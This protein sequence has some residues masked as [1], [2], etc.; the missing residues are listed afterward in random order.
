MQYTER[1]KLALTY[2]EESSKRAR[3]I[4]FILQL[5]VIVVLASLWQQA[6][7]NWLQQRL[8]AA[9]DLVRVL[10]CQPDKVYGEAVVNEAKKSVDRGPSLMLTADA[11]YLDS[12]YSCAAVMKDDAKVK[13]AYKYQK[14]WGFSLAEAK[15]NVSDLQQLMVNRVLGVSFPVLG[16][17][18]DVNDLSLLAGVTFVIL[19]SWFH[20]ALRRQN[21]NIIHV[22][23]IARQA[24][25]SGKEPDNCLSVTYYLLAMTQVLTIPPADE[26]DTQKPT[27]FAKMGKLSNLIMSTAV[28]AQALVL[29]DD[30]LTMARGDT[31]SPIVNYI[32]SGLAALLWFYLIFRTKECYKIMANTQ[33]VW[34]EAFNDAR[35]SP[36]DRRKASEKGQLPPVSS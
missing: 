28:V 18:F 8:Y 34:N 12:K 29:I 19:L 16:V 25:L 7:S 31:L 32:E 3:W 33:T 4:V 13:R 1:I 5:A 24:D 9:Q 36:A 14:D 27:F 6:D 15:K 10:S 35:I 11:E 21:K 30:G 26:K 22:F 20:F 2:A 23:D 17:V